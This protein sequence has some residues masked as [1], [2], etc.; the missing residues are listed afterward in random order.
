MKYL[1]LFE[2]IDV[3]DSKR[4]TEVLIRLARLV[5]SEIV[6]YHHPSEDFS[7]SEL[8]KLAIGEDKLMNVINIMLD[9]VINRYHEKNKNTKDE[10]I[11]LGP[12]HLKHHSICPSY[13]DFSINFDT[14]EIIDDSEDYGLVSNS[15]HFIDIYSMLC[16][17]PKIAGQFI[18]FDDVKKIITNRFSI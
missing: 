5:S 10:E 13:S 2:N 8:Y 16:D 7:V 17:N 14:M 9:E 3:K 15:I 1:K 4:I 12:K 11:K 18:T 6:D